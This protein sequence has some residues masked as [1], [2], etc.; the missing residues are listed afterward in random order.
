M[1][2]GHKT[3][4][5]QLNTREIHESN[6]RRGG[7]S[8]AG[9]RL[10]GAVG[11]A[12]LETEGIAGVFCEED[13]DEPGHGAVVSEVGTDPPEDEIEGGESHKRLPPEG[14]RAGADEV[15]YFVRVGVVA[16]EM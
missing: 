11:V 6:G 16:S 15:F 13:A 4:R 7:Q 5:V 9:L 2:E 3:P 10:K 14:L 1:K 8:P 12:R